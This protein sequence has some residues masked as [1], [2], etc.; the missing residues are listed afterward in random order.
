[1][2]SSIK[3]QEWSFSPLGNRPNLLC[4]KR[5]RKD[6][7]QLRNGVGT[8]WKS[9][10]YKM[11]ATHLHTY[12]MA[13]THLHTYKMAAKHLHTYKMVATHL[14]NYKMTVT[15]LQNG[16]YILK[17]GSFLISNY[18][19][20]LII[21]CTVLRMLLTFHP[22]QVFNLSGKLFSLTET[23]LSEGS[24]DIYMKI[25]YKVWSE[26]LTLG[27]HLQNLS[28]DGKAILIWII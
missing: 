25:D 15:H 5:K 19:R 11:A 7:I 8:P 14:H 24:K 22:V 3:F 16:T 2:A 13:A 10:T 26:K 20:C 18:K 4:Q 28:L 27:E 21:T 1:L 17:N 23:L 12:K 9:H 6:L